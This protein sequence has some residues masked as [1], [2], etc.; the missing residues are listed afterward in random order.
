[1]SINLASSLSAITTD[2]TTGVTHI[3]WADNGNIWHAVYDNNSETWKNAEAIAFTG[4]EPVTSLNLVASGQLIDGSNPGLAVVWQQ[5]NLND[6][7][8]F[9]T[10]AQYDENANLQWLDTPQ[11]LTSDQVGDLEP[12]VTVNN[13]GKVIVIGSKVNFDN[14]ANLSIKEDT[15]FYTQTFSVSSS[16]FSTSTSNVIPTAPYSPQLTNNG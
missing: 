5:G 9:Y 13:S 8:F 12:T 1:M 16:Q 15:D 3:V 2:S 11:T 14:V 4:T 7:D 6:S 10:A